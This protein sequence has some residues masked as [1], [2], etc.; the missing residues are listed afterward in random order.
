MAVAFFFLG[1]HSK[2]SET[3]GK[4][5]RLYVDFLHTILFTPLA[6][7]RAHSLTYLGGGKNRKNERGGV[8]F[9]FLFFLFLFPDLVPRFV[10][11]LE[12]FPGVWHCGY[13]RRILR[14]G[15]R[16]RINCYEVWSTDTTTQRL[17]QLVGEGEKKIFSL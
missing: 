8:F 5:N 7:Q 13:V 1:L 15:V 14:V 10:I 2:K 6:A 9:F 3:Q 4:K 11:V 16:K 17:Y 12:G